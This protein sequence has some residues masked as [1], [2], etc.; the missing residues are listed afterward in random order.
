MT[1]VHADGAPDGAA[2]PNAPPSSLRT[3][4][5]R[6]SVAAGLLAAA[7]A[8]RRRRV[9]PRELSR[10]ELRAL[11]DNAPDTV[12]RFD[13]G[14][15]IRFVNPVVEV[16]TGLA[17]A[18][19]LGRTV[20][21]I[22]LP[23]ENVRES[24]DAL[25]TV[26]ATQRPTVMEFSFET[27]VGMRYFESRLVPEF[28]ADGAMQSVLGLTREVTERRVAEVT[29]RRS[30]AF[31]AEGQRI[32]HTGSWSR[33]CVTGAV[34]WS[35]EQYRIFGA[36][37]AVPRPWPSEA[38]GALFWERVHPA[39]RPFVR[40]TYE[41]GMRDF[42]PVALEYRIV[43]AD[44][45]VRHIASEG[46]RGEGDDYI[47]T[48][49]DVTD[50]VRA[51]RRLRRA[52]KAR[53]EAALAERTRIARDMHDGLLQDVTAIALQLG[54]VLPHASTTP[55][56]AARLAG[57]L[58]LA[59]QAGRQARVAVQGMRR[60]GDAVDLVAAVQAAAQRAT[61][62]SALALTVRVS[63]R[64]CLVP[65]PTCDAAVSIVQEAIANVVTHAEART[66]RLAVAFG[67][68]RLRLSVRDDGRGMPPPAAGAGGGVG[69]FGLV[70]MRERAAAVGA[71][72]VVSTVP[73][74]GT[75]I[76]LEAPLRP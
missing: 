26:L 7:F 58:R 30:E 25:G 22:G 57:I 38:L 34:V 55:E 9:G 47:G 31:L 39:D 23:P 63:G 40:R 1:S 36:D 20:A 59:E 42:T 43:L 52:I 21:E 33:N 19:M 18:A 37:P 10:R 12:I 49:M 5:L 41:Q 60:G 15:R 29:A 2:R 6:G 3:R 48:I 28:G 76:R 72:L 17:P 44:G 11:I 4:W 74:R 35:D 46:R 56:V 13:L 61:A 54:A 50:R 24:E 70:G 68:T 75:L 27:P 14:L 16:Y 51:N 65:P 62:P 53:Y 69:H 45:T 67:R 73:G 71:G 66:V 64:P 32:S 8:A